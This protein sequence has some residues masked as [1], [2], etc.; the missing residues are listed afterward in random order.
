MADG[1][2]YDMFRDRHRDFLNSLKMV[3]VAFQRDQD[4]LRI[5]FR[6]DARLPPEWLKSLT[7]ELFH[8]VYGLQE[9]V[10]DLTWTDMEGS[11]LVAT[12]ARPKKLLPDRD[13]PSLGEICLPIGDVI[14]FTPNH[15][16]EHPMYN[17]SGARVMS[18]QFDDL[19]TVTGPVEEILS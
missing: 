14:L 7:I 1:D 16:N 8:E 9:T 4:R 6:C 10:T 18:R 17:E 2:V 3:W 12:C 15:A 5:T 19:T 11:L 13:L